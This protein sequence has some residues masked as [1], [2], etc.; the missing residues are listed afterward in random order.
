M[1]QQDEEQALVSTFYLGD[2]LFGISYIEECFYIIYNAAHI[3]RDACG[4]D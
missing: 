2:A 1:F 3:K 4:R